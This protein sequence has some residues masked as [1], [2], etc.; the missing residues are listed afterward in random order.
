MILK[1]RKDIDPILREPTETVTDFGHE[2]QLFIDNMIETMRKSNG[3]GLAAPQV[4]V[5]KKVFICEFEGDK[6][7]N[8]PPFPLTVM[9][10]PEIVY[11]SKEKKKMV[12]GCLSFPGLELL[13]KRPENIIIKGQDRFGEKIE[14]KADKLYARVMQHE[15]DHLNS[16]LMIDRLEQIKVIFI[17]TGSM[18]A[19]AL[20]LLARDPQYLIDFVIT[21]DEKEIIGRNKQAARNPIAEIAKKNKLELIHTKRIRTDSVLIE[22]IKKSK[23]DLGIVADFGQIIPKEVIDIPEHGI[24]NIHPSLLPKYRG[25]APIQATILNGDEFAG[26]SIMTIDEKMDAG[27]IVSQAKV[28]LSTSDTTTTLKEYLSE[29]GAALLLNTIPYY[30]AGDLS[31]APQKEDEATF[32]QMVQKEDGLVDVNTDKA[33]VNRKIRAYDEWPKAY[34][35]VNNKRVQLLSSHFEESG[36]LVI[37]RVKPEGKKEM[38]YQDFLRGYKTKLTFH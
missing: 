16:T 23:P 32:T 26:V 24:L 10:N 1:I 33:T 38:S 8:L 15:F 3:V 22:K 30:M 2:F 34:T 7:I 19:K 13:I 11:Q 28:E 29:I 20:K 18:G 21:S 36:E 37:D 27:G 14:I 35:M 31:P 17:G 12:E 25:S 4:G 5:S 9:V 6:E